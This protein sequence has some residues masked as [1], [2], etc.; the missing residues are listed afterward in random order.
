MNDLMLCFRL[1]TQ[2]FDLG[3]W[4]DK[5]NFSRGVNARYGSRRNF[6]GFALILSPAAV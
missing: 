6:N 1:F 2:E 4:Y 5:H 3:N